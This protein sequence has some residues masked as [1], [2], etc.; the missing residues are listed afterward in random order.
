VWTRRQMTFWSEKLSPSTWLK[1]VGFSE[2]LS[3]YEPKRNRNPEE[4]RR[5]YCHLFNG[6]ISTTQMKEG[7]YRC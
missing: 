6:A 3:T 5:R 1:K 4:Q 2:T 7:D